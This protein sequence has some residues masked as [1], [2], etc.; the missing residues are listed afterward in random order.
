M[1]QAVSGNALD[2]SAIE[3]DTAVEKGYLVS[4]VVYLKESHCLST[5]EHCIFTFL[6]LSFDKKDITMQG[7]VPRKFLNF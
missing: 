7:P 3:A 6:E 5:G 2:H 1:I 4:I